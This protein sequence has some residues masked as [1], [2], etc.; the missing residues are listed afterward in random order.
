MKRIPTTVAVTLLAFAGLNLAITPK[1]A[2]EDD[3]KLDNL[4]PTVRAAIEARAQGGRI[5]EIERESENGTTYYEAEIVKDGKRSEIAVS[6]NGTELKGEQ[7]DDERGERAERGE[8]GEHGERGERRERGERGERGEYGEHHER[9]KVGEKEDDDDDD[10]A[11]KI[12]WNDLPQAVK[13]TVTKT[14]PK[15]AFE[16]ISSE[17]E[18]G[19]TVYEVECQEGHAKQTLKLTGDGYLMEVEQPTLYEDLPPGVQL[20]IDTAFHGASFAHAETVKLT[21]YEVEL[22]GADGK[23]T[24]ARILANGQV[25]PAEDDD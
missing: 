9:G 13:D 22:N 5:T 2:A 6:E 8:R 18:D 7:D 21:V 12:S 4:P 23:R 24:E 1:C 10:Q 19:H 16:D 14:C 11:A 25:L 20:A 17:V 15:A 3:V